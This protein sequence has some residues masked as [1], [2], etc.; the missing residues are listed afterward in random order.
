M[1]IGVMQPYFLPYVGYFQLMHAC[2]QFVLY[3]DVTFITRGWINRNRLLDNG[4][5]SYFT[6]P[7]EKSSQNRLI[8]KHKISSA[9]DRWK[10]KFVKRID[11]LYCKAP[12][13]EVVAPLMAKIVHHSSNDLVEYLRHSLEAINDYLNLSVT[14]KLSSA[15]GCD[16]D[17]GCDARI[18]SMC[19]TLGAT[20]YLNLPGGRDL[21]NVDDFANNG[22]RLEF[23][24][25]YD[26]SYV[27]FENAF[28]PSLS[29]L[30]VLMFNSATDV[31]SMIKDYKVSNGKTT[32]IVNE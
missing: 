19:K 4:K 23:L 10:R 21:Y 12:Y 13:Y 6:L 14:I 24:E 16:A 5:A 7:L 29:I 8:C 20:V 31:V 26:K 3:D 15:I 1:R 22:I 30:D 11:H 2:K 9:A 18:V 28:V 25:F 32:G 27:Q 17:I